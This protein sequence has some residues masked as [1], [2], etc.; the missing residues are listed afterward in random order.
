MNKYTVIAVLI[1]LSVTIETIS[2]I[3]WTPASV[4]IT[5]D[6]DTGAQPAA[7]QIDLSKSLKGDPDFSWKATLS[8]CK[9]SAII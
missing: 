2:A 8:N 5:I 4:N 3:K 7:F 6:L 1:L 9:Y